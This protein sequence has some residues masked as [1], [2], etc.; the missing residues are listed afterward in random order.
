MG[1]IGRVVPIKDVKT[2]L[3][4]ARLV[5]EQCS[6]VQFLIAGPYSEDRDYF[7]ECQKIVKLLKIEDKVDFLGKQKLMEIIPRIDVM[8]LTSI[9][10][11]LPLVVLE[12]MAA[13]IPTVATD[14]GACRELIFGRTAEDKSLGR[15][16]R[17]T[18]ILSPQETA[19]SLI[20]ILQNP[21]VWREM[22]NAGRKRVEEYYTME[23]MLQSYRE[24]YRNLTDPESPAS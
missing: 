4:A 6:D 17:L 21:D 3:R 18:K 24:L 14:V 9:S 19:Q 2:L 1:F 7:E 10:E 22:G 16:G 13:G 23:L 20:G 15:A 11:G 12:A 8:V 5:V